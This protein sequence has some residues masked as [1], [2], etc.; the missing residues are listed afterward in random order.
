MGKTS[1]IQTNF[2]GGELSPFLYGRVDVAKYANGAAVMENVHPIVQG[3]A[4]SRPGLR[5]LGTALGEGFL[6]PFVYSREVAYI[7]EL[8][9][10]KLRVW[11]ND[12]TLLAVDISTPYGLAELGDVTFEQS[13]DTMFFFHVDHPINRLQRHSDAVWT[14]GQPDWVTLPFAERGFS[15]VSVALTLS[16][17]SVGT[18]RT[19]TSLTA[20]FVASDVGRDL[21]GAAGGRATVTGFTSD[22][23]I[24]V[25]VG[26]AFPSTTVSSW[27]LEGSP[28]MFLYPAAKEPVGSSTTLHAALPRAADITLSALTGS[29]TIDASAGVFSAG[30]TGKTLYA[31]A[32]TVVLTYVSATQCTGT[33]ST[34][35]LRTS[36]QAGAWG[37]TGDGFRVEDG[38][39]FANVNGGLFK[40]TSLASA[41]DATAEIRVSPSAL[42]AAPPGSWTLGSDVFGSAAGFPRCGALHEQRLWMAG[43]EAYPSDVWASRIGEYLDFEAGLNDADGFSYTLTSRQR[44]PVRHLVSGKRLFVLT[45]GGEASLRGGNEKAIGPTN[46]QKDNESSFGANAVRPV[47]IGKEVLYVQG[48]GRKVRALGYSAA[49]D[50]FDSPDRTV[51]AEHVTLSGVRDMA[52]QPQDFS[53]LYCVRNDGQM[54]VAAYDVGQEVVAWSRYRTDGLF[55]SVTVVPNGDRDD[56]WALVDRPGADGMHRYFVER[57]DETLCTDSA[58]VVAL[59]IGPGDTVDYIDGLDRFEG[60]SLPVKIAGVY[61]GDMP[62]SGG[63]ITLA[64]PA[65]N[66]EAGLPFVP[67]IELLPPE[68]GGGGGTAQGSNVSVHEVAIRVLDTQALEVNGAETD[69]RRFGAALLD[70]PPPGFTGDYRVVKLTDNFIKDK[71]VIRQPKPYKCHVQ[72]VIRKVTVNDI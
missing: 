8:T 3:G 11:R 12:G 6:V 46:I 48:A 2:S 71:L 31:D 19:M 66:I 10:G 26:E 60:R 51:F 54:A 56:V 9:D 68:V 67:T 61:Q 39:S 72:A 58:S 52:Y 63:R 13:E 24:T 32:G 44:N 42:V 21:I 62:V 41:A 40:I 15:N 16:N 20:A 64:A 65:N 37:I 59:E 18:G 27:T 23:S 30:D 69:F 55:R 45:T 47:V 50:G 29:I 33:T 17:A 7:V 22:T 38:G 70:Q 36:Y 57:F 14:M 34:D 4:V 28:Q 5:Y 1:V 35:F 49:I 43:S 25:D 53:L